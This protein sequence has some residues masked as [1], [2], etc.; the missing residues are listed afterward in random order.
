MKSNLAIVVIVA[1]LAAAAT[2]GIERFVC[3]RAP[4][5]GAIITPPDSTGHGNIPINTIPI[6]V[7]KLQADLSALIKERKNLQAEIKGLQETI[8]A[9][10]LAS[11]QMDSLLAAA[12]S[13]TTKLKAA[14]L[15]AKKLSDANAARLKAAGD[16]LSEVTKRLEELEHSGI[17]LLYK[18][19]DLVLRPGISGYAGFGTGKTYTGGQAWD[20]SKLYGDAAV[21]LKL[22]YWQNKLGTYTGGV[23]QSFIYPKSGMWV[24][25]HLN[26]L[27]FKNLEIRVSVSKNDEVFLKLKEGWEPRLGLG[28]DF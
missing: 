11:Q 8:A 1:V 17:P 12:G 9:S 26:E 16:K 19:F 28:L 3:H 18:K 14:L 20:G 7:A 21:S 13:D 22:W 15:E 4:T 2:F 25:R 10:S 27:G 6:E 5:P 23:E 24:G